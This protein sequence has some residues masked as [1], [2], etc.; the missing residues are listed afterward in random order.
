[1][2]KADT[3]R[4]RERNKVEALY[5]LQVLIRHALVP[6]KQRRPTAPGRKAK[7]QRLRQKARR[8]QIKAQRK[9]VRSD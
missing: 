6:R 7:E 3:H 8:S 1:V 4:S 2:L 5:R 9:A